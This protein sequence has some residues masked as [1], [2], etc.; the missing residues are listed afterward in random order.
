MRCQKVSTALRCPKC[1]ICSRCGHVRDQRLSK[2]FAFCNSLAKRQV[3]R[4]LPSMNSIKAIR[5]S[6][7]FL[8][9]MVEC[10]CSWF[11]YQQLRLSPRL[12]NFLLKDWCKAPWFTICHCLPIASSEIDFIRRPILESRMNPPGVVKIHIML[13]TETELRQ[14]DIL[15]DFDVLIFQRP[16]ETFHFCIIQ[17]SSPSVHADLNAMV[18]KFR[19]KLRAGKLASLIRI[20]NLRFPVGIHRCF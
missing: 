11:R 18:P 17:T 19:Y 15:F 3:C 5:M 20:E 12:D 7:Q 4:L 2:I 1:W 8:G 9:Y 14:A 6:R 10:P 13:N 16:P